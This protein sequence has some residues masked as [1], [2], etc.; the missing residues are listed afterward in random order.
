[1]SDDDRELVTLSSAEMRS[2]TAPASETPPHRRTLVS[3]DA[4]RSLGQT[5]VGR[6]LVGPGTIVH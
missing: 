1:M 2:G 4:L 3:R 6:W 5:T